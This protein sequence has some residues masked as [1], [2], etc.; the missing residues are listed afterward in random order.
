MDDEKLTNAEYVSEEE[1]NNPEGKDG[2]ELDPIERNQVNLGN[3]D[4][5][6]DEEDE[7]AKKALADGIAGDDD[8]HQ[9][10]PLNEEND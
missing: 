10:K 2:E 1:L 8:N 6:L 4:S 7:D 5:E 3:M 9:D